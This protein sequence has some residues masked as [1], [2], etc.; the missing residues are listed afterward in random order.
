VVFVFDGSMDD[1]PNGE[2]ETK[3]YKDIIQ[4]C[5]EKKYFYPQIVLTCIDKLERQVI[6]EEEDKVGQSMGEMDKEQKI[7]ELVDMKLERVV[8]KLGVS[9]SSVHFIENYKEGDVMNKL[10]IDY[11]ALRLLHECVQQCDSFL[12]SNIAEKTKCAIF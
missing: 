6:E 7:R 5:R 4:R 1:I 2:E 10:Q 12:I 11:K 8:L 3:F 9:R